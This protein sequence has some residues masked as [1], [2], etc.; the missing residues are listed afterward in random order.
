MMKAHILSLVILLA[1]LALPTQAQTTK[2]QPDKPSFPYLVDTLLTGGCH[3]TLALSATVPGTDSG[4]STD[5]IALPG[6]MAYAKASVKISLVPDNGY[7][8]RPGYPKVYKTGGTPADI[9]A[10]TETSSRS[11]TFEMPTYAVTVDMAYAGVLKNIK[12]DSLILTAPVSTA[13]DV[14]KLLP[15]KQPVYL[16]N[17]A[18]D[19]L[20]VTPGTWAL[21]GTFNKAEGAVNTFTCALTLPDSIVQNGVTLTGTLQVTNYTVPPISSIANE[22]DLQAFRDAVNKGKDYTDMTVSLTADFTLTE[23]SWTPIG[24]YDTRKFNG[25]FDGQGHCISGLNINLTDKTT[26]TV[27]AGLFGR[28]AAKGIVQNLGVKGGSIYV[29]V[30]NSV[31]AGGIAGRN[32]GTINNCYTDINVKAISL[33]TNKSVVVGGIAGCNTSVIGACYTLGEIRSGGYA[34]GIAGNNYSKDGDISYCFASG[35][36]SGTYSGGIT[37]NVKSV[38]YCIALNS[39]I[40]GSQ[41][42]RISSNYDVDWHKDNYASPI[43]PGQWNLIGEQDG[44]DLTERN[45]ITE[46]DGIKNAFNGWHS[47]SDWNFDDTARLPLLM[48]A[49][50]KDGNRVLI[51]GQGDASGK[52]AARAD[53]MPVKISTATDYNEA[54]HNNKYIDIVDGGDF[55][56]AADGS[57]ASF[58]TVTVADGGRLTMSTSADKHSIK[59]LI[60]EDGAQV[61]VEKAFNLNTLLSSPYTIGNHWTAVGSQ[62]NT[63]VTMADYKLTIFYALTGYSAADADKQKWNPVAK[64]EECNTVPISSLFLL[65]IEGADHAVT[66]SA[67]A[68]SATT[69]LVVQP[70]AAPTTGEALHTGS[71]LFC[72]NRTLHDLTI[73]MAYI[74]SDNGTRFE[75]TEKAVVKP[76][77]SYMVANAVTSAAVMSLRVG[78]DTP[79]ANAPVALTDDTFRVWGVN[80]QLHL[81]ADTPHEVTVYNLAGQLVRRFTL[82]GEETLTLPR[83]IYLVN[84]TDSTNRS[85]NITY[86]VS[87]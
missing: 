70:D 78:N 30:D 60:V 56:V 34:G 37:N 45:F 25:T 11:F 74:L 63:T 17:D 42:Y 53:F 83:G 40:A 86:K 87:L 15:T 51:A 52:M 39:S 82:D 22:A 41:M 68:T 85:T 4:S 1:A 48:T 18:I 65:A 62:F 76:F 80:G 8:A 54:L 69:P 79:T 7:K 36:A 14:I 6:N 46:Q 31:Y 84:S 47:T 81:S 66:F 33:G 19:S 13:D 29:E 26:P 73:P 75:R 72:A 44:D 32:D 57:N 2:A 9:V 12:T 24:N 64:T 35:I 71:F 28:I 16:Q 21:T 10:I 49:K 61:F 59:K 20:A 5:Y 50:D 38:Q 55:K 77:Q 67:K 58:P 3:G 23:A 43:I 27:A